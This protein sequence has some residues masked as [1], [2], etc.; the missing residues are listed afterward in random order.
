[1][2]VTEEIL[3]SDGSGDKI[4]LTCDALEGNQTVLVS[5]D[6][7]AS[8]SSRSQSVTFSAGGI[9]QVLTVNQEPGVLEPI[10]Y[11]YLYFTR[12]AYVQTDFI[13]PSLASF[14]SVF[15]HETTNSGMQRIFGAGASPNLIRFQYVS[16]TTS[17]SGRRFAIYYGSS[18]NISG[19]LT[20][21]WSN[22]EYVFFLTPKRYG[23]A[24]TTRAISKGSN[25]PTTGLILGG[26]D[27]SFTGRMSTFYVYD[28]SAQN[29]TSYSE[30]TAF[31][32]IATFRP[33]TYGGQAGFWYVEGNKFF[34]NSADSGS[35]T[36]SN[37]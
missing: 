30:L 18:S 11:N 17:S 4:Y 37:T 6:A 32:P 28:S 16:N 24:S 20:Y 13:L 12:P 3:W 8:A 29:A 21:A 15:G 2:A 27:N 33:C 31:T 1:M 14:S 26:A 10:F 19:N 34:G 9:S 5:S 23:F 25:Y 36:A 7:N 22:T 35:L